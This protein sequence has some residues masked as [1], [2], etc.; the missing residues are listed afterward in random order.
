MS[1][2][3]FIE[4]ELRNT[5]YHITIDEE[6]EYYGLTKED[7]LEVMTQ[8]E[9]DD[10]ELAELHIDEMADLLDEFNVLAQIIKTFEV[11]H[12]TKQD[13]LNIIYND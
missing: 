13:I 6:Y 12:F 3:E 7:V 10:F 11:F 8:E 9:I 2:R 1:D 5:L 4:T